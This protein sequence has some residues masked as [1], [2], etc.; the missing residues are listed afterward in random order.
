MTIASNLNRLMKQK[1]MTYEVLQGFA[2][3]SPESIAHASDKRITTCTL[4]ML[5]RIALTLDVSVKELIDEQDILHRLRTLRL[6]ATRPKHSSHKKP[7]TSG[8]IHFPNGFRES[9]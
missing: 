4:G 3:I 9:A 8:K 2:Q 6:T 1:G 7:Q 5:E